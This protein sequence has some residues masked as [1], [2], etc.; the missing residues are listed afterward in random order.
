M[1]YLKVNHDDAKPIF[2]RVQLSVDSVQWLD[3]VYTLI[4]CQSVEVVP[5]V[6]RGI[7]LIIDEEGKLYD[8]WS[9]R[10]NTVA[11]ILYGSRS[12][13]IVG[14]A[15]LARMSGG[16]LLPLTDSD[17]DRITRYFLC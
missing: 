12:D 10:I 6:L 5:T 15:I 17:I 9:S 3:D 1:S 7:Y 8:D 11:T 13:V 16:D 14:D 4:C 2:E